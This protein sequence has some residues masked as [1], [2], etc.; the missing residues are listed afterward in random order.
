MKNAAEAPTNTATQGGI[1]YLYYPPKG[2]PVQLP[3][4]GSVG[5][6]AL[7]AATAR[8]AGMI[9]GIPNRRITLTTRA[10]VSAD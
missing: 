6:N 5:E 2:S 7:R 10:V 4:Q 1:R 9:V 3:M 8:V